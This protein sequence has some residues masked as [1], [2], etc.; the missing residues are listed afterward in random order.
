MKETDKV[1]LHLHD[2]KDEIIL[3]GIY[4]KKTHDHII[5]Y[6]LVERERLSYLIS[7]SLEWNEI[8][9]YGFFKE[10]S[11]DK[12]IRIY[13][14]FSDIFLYMKLHCNKNK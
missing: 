7:S 11:S 2:L 10:K 1:I 8:K 13:Q 5:R 6:L 4:R 9:L 12:L 14:M 3:S